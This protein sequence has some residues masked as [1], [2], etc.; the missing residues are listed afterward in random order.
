MAE[1]DFKRIEEHWQREWAAADAFAAKTPTERENKAYVLVQFPYP[2]GELHMGHLRAYAIGDVVARY[3]RLQDRNVLNPMGWDAFGLPAEQS[4]I[5]HGVHPRALTEQAIVNYRRQLMS[6]GISYDWNREVDTSSPEYYRWTQWLFLKLYELGL[7][8]KKLAPVNWCPNHG[9]LANEEAA[10][11]TCWRCD[12]PVIRR[13]LSQWFVRTTEFAEELLAGLEE[14]EGWPENFKAMQRNWIGRSEGTR[15]TFEIP[16]LGEQ[17]EVFTTRADTLFGVTFVSIAPEHP[18]ADRL[19]EAGG[20]AD[21]LK[22][23]REQVAK[24]TTIERSTDERDKVGLNLGVTAKHPLTGAE[25]AIFAA[26]YV[27]MEYGTGIVMGVPAHDTRDFAFAHKY[28]ISIVRVINNEDGTESELP[29]TDYGMMVNSGDYDGMAS[30]DGI[31]RLNADLSARGKGGGT[32]Q[33]KL[34]DWLVSRQRYW[35]VPIPMVSCGKCGHVPVPYEEL[36]VLL[37]EAVEFSGET[38]ARLATNREFIETKC[39]KCGGPAERE[40]DTMSTFVCSSW[41][42][43]RYTDP[44]NATAPFD[45]EVCNAWMPVDNYIGGKEHVVGHML[46]SRFICHS[47]HRAGLINFTEP[48]LRYFSQGILYKDGAK[49]SKSR[50]NV[51]S[52]DHFLER[53]GADTGRMISLFWGP[54]ERDVEWQEGGVEGCFRFLKRLHAFYTEV[55]PQVAGAGEHDSSDESAGAK[56]ILHARHLAVKDITE[57]M[58]AW[59]L[60]TVVSSLMVFLNQLTEAWEGMDESR[61]A[62]ANLR[63]LMAEAL[64][65]LAVMLSPIAPHLAEELWHLFGQKDFVMHSRWPKYDESFL[66]QDEVEYG[67]S[68]N[69]KP[70]SRIVLPVDMLDDEVQACALADEKVIPHIE[71]KK[72]VKVIVI[73]GRLVNIVVK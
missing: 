12:A 43:L 30:R 40:A 7:V 4:A 19:A 48:F 31:R 8:Y 72:V 66:A 71:G 28:G 63:A 21:E 22:A 46:Y 45:S 1:Y 54:P 59:R 56:A 9:V 73:R 57:S 20:T 34:R 36:P 11:G 50:G 70:R 69:G 17:V 47:L 53:Y 67:I 2:S 39:P 10:D 25:V 44:H 32:I 16:A 42:Y 41:Y 6:A 38:D 58:D 62:D 68:V 3:R 26:D 14:M 23:F 18:L 37:P 27:L 60:N 15:I 5:D 64:V 55:W 13:N 61:R 52:I 33:Y 51:V 35:G 29:F 49:M 24:Q 65:T